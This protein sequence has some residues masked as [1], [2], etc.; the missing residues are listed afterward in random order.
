MSWISFAISSTCKFYYKLFPTLTLPELGREL[1][2]VLS[3][4]RADNIFDKVCFKLLPR[5]G[6]GRD[7][8]TIDPSGFT[9]RITTPCHSEAS[10]MLCFN[11]SAVFRILPD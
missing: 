3:G 1:N 9:L 11:D 6:E 2:R 7:G 10:E 5:L 8:E 4:Y